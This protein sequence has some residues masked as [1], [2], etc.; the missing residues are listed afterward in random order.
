MH[1]WRDIQKHQQSG[2]DP[3]T[4][5]AGA[6]SASTNVALAGRLFWDVQSSWHVW[7][8]ISELPCPHITEMGWLRKALSP[9]AGPTTLERPGRD[10]ILVY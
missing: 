6:D 3:G 1:F 5:G 9:V 8:A 7:S 2:M 10:L 4:R